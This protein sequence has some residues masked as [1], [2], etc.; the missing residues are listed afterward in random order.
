MFASYKTILIEFLYTYLHGVLLEIF[1]QHFIKCFQL[2]YV[3]IPFTLCETFKL[4]W[5]WPFKEFSCLQIQK[6]QTFSI[7]Q[8]F[9]RRYLERL[10]MINF[11]GKLL[12]LHFLNI[13]WKKTIY[14]VKKTCKAQNDFWLLLRKMNSISNIMPSLD[15][16]FHFRHVK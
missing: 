8:V 11:P 2:S 3:L 10:W 6:V 9:S 1:K 15:N 7:W 5:F 4:C 16:V 12:K 13:S 14:W